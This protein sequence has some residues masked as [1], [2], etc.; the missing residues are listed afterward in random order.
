MRFL[1]RT[2]V[3]TFFIYPVLVIAWGA[4]LEQRLP[5]YPAGVLAGHGMGLSAV[6]AL[7]SLSHQTWWRRSRPR[8]PRTASSQPDLTPIPAI[9][10]ISVISLPSRIEFGITLLAR[11][12][13]HDRRCVVVSPSSHRRRKK[14]SN[15]A[16]QA[17]P[18]VYEESATL[19]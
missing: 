6:P 18:G 4:Y 9:R 16:R 5:R 7:W 1:S 12:C 17:L 15:Q 14:L 8:N 19:D 2:P 11:R 10:C 3:R 13:D